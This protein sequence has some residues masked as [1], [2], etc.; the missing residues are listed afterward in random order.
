MPGDRE[1]PDRLP[2]RLNS[3]SKSDANVF[4]ACG[5][6]ACGCPRLVAGRRH[7]LAWVSETQ[8]L[9]TTLADLPSLLARAGRE[10]AG[11]R[12][13]RRAR[14]PLPHPASGRRHAARPCQRHRGRRRLLRARPRPSQWRLA[15]LATWT[16]PRPFARRA[17]P[18]A[19]PP[20]AQFPPPPP[21]DAD[22]PTTHGLA[23]FRCGPLYVRFPARRHQLVDFPD[24][25]DDLGFPIQSDGSSTVIPGLH[26]MGVHF[27]RKRKSATFLGAAEDAAVLAETPSRADARLVGVTWEGSSSR[28]RR[29]RRRSTPR[30][31]PGTQPP[32]LTTP[33]VSRRRATRR[34]RRELAVRCHG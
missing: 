23:R 19:H 20:R 24:A 5:R 31:G 14:P 10:P 12:P 26:F 33:P 9:E 11:H 32:T 3:R 4:L 18:W 28:S 1:R 8:F 27:Q 7:R 6:V 17:R 22:P 16:S 15:M 13:V 25:F 30:W 2:G 21:F 34:R 29:A